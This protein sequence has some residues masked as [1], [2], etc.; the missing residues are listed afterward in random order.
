MSGRRPNDVFKRV[1][2]RVNGVMK[3]I[4]GIRIFDAKHKGKVYVYAVLV[5][6]DKLELEKIESV[7]GINTIY[8]R[9][10]EWN[11]ALQK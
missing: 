1:Y 7:I 10:V 6:S 9:G 11:D 8:F 5:D 4:D 3:P 2:R